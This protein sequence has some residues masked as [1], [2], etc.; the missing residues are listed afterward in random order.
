MVWHPNKYA[1]LL[2]EKM[3]K[4]NVNA[5]LVNTGW[6]GGSFGTGKRMKLKFTRSM[7]DSINNGSLI[8]QEFEEGP[9]GLMIPK[10]CENV[11][12]E[13]LMPRKTWENKEKY[14][15]TLKKLNQL[16]ANNFEQF[17]E[18]CDKEIVESGPHL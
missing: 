7:I 17:K 9:F 2:A 12:D 10:K 11:P 18:K 3:K 15:E 13:I 6:T 14:D 1:N 8:K 16:F 5:W 4:N